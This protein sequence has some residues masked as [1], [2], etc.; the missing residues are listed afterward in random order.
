MSD[1]DMIIEL[2]EITE[3]KEGQEVVFTDRSIEIITELGNKYAQTELY[4]RERANN[5]DWEG[6]SNAG[7]LYVYMCDR[8]AEAP[9]VIHMMIAPKLL[10]PII[11]KKLQ[12]ETGMIFL[13]KAAT[14][15]KTQTM[16]EEMSD[17]YERWNLRGGNTVLRNDE[18]GNARTTKG[19]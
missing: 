4:K 17:I 2:L 13:T 9:S 7:L 18:K 19:H 5:P 3:V 15:G 12:E 8:I 10:L 6:D 16:L 1:K 11:L 14:V